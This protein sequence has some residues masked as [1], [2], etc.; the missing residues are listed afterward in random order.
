ML[1]PDPAEPVGDYGASRTLGGP[2]GFHAK[3]RS[4]PA[5]ANPFVGAF[6]RRP[7]L[8][9]TGDPFDECEAG[10]YMDPEFDQEVADDDSFFEGMNKIKL[11]RH[12]KLVDNS[13]AATGKEITRDKSASLA[14]YTGE[15][16]NLINQ[17]KFVKD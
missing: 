11:D 15:S 3:R 5:A 10:N 17:M 7:R 6:A 9:E 4:Q 13:V 2:G 8:L 14:S 1:I 16:A 12:G